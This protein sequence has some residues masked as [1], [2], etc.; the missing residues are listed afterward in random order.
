MRAILIALALTVTGCPPPTAPTHPVEVTQTNYAKVL[1]SM[2]SA[3]YSIDTK[4][5]SAGVVTTAWEEQHGTL[6][7]WLRL[8]LAVTVVDGKATVTSQCQVQDRSDTGGI[9][10]SWQ[11]CKA[12]P[13]GQQAKIERL[14][15][16]LRSGL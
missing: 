10:H 6:Q 16:S 2:T 13:E 5:E 4:D 8:R 7:M 12:Q 9:D 1:R 15:A 14:A 3:G 11:T